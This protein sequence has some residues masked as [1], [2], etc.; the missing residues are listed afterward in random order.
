MCSG[1]S[2]TATDLASSPKED[3][4]KRQSHHTLICVNLGLNKAPSI[5]SLDSPV[6]FDTAPDIRFPEH[7]VAFDGRQ[8]PIFPSSLTLRQVLLTNPYPTS[9]FL[10]SPAKRCLNSADRL[11]HSVDLVQH[12]HCQPPQVTLA[13]IVDCMDVAW[14]FLAAL[15][16]WINTFFG[17]QALSSWTTPAYAT[18]SIIYTF[19]RDESNRWNESWESPHNLQVQANL[20]LPFAANLPI[21][22]KNMS[23][24]TT[25]QARNPF[26]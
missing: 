12:S 7:I 11:F 15:P 24:V 17:A 16:S 5:L 18:E 19:L 3:R 1:H 13:S 26:Q 22:I 4:H 25:T 2:A 21:H 6:H 14:N 23:L 20:L 9:G 10:A 8:P